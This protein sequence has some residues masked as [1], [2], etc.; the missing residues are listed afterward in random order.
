M[1]L[2]DGAMRL[3][4]SVTDCEPEIDSPMAASCASCPFY[5][6]SSTDRPGACRRFPLSAQK[7]A[8]EICG[9][10]PM[11]MAVRPDVAALEECTRLLSATS[12][13]LAKVM[14]MLAHPPLTAE[15]EKS[16]KLFGKGKR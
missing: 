13:A 14:Q 12:E 11:Q 1:T 15:A 7:W 2:D 9:E 8:N 5:T 10:H 4:G 3:A 6:A 16:S